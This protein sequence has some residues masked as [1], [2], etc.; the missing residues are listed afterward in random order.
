M[1]KHRSNF[2]NM[3]TSGRMR[4]LVELCWVGMD[5]AHKDFINLNN[6]WYNKKI[7]HN[8]L[9]FWLFLKSMKKCTQKP[10]LLTVSWS[11]IP[12]CLLEKAHNPI[13][14]CLLMAYC[15]PSNGFVFFFFLIPGTHMYVLGNGGFLDS[16]EMCFPSVLFTYTVCQM[17]TY[18]YM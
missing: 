2:V 1:N 13:F 4:T 9:N 3:I 11:W 6:K 10:S 17:L 7:S 14:T 18:N 5:L 8:H 12:G 15:H 16:L